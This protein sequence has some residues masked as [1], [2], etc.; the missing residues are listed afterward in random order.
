MDRLRRSARRLFARLAARLPAVHADLA[1]VYA[2]APTLAP[3]RPDAPRPRI[4]MARERVEVEL[5]HNVAVVFAVFEMRNLDDA[6]ELDVAFPSVGGNTSFPAFHGGALHR[7]TA[8][9]GPAALW[10]APIE[11]FG[12]PADHIH[13]VERTGDGGDYPAWQVWRQRFAR[14]ITVVK[15]R[16]VC[17]FNAFK[18]GGRAPFTY[19]LRTGGFWHGPIGEAVVRV[20]A[21][22]VPL[23][24]I[25]EAHPAGY[26]LDAAAGSL[27]WRFVDLDPQDDISLLISQRVVTTHYRGVVPESVVGFNTRRAE[28]GERVL[29]GGRLDPGAPGSDRDAPFIGGPRLVSERWW[30]LNVLVPQG[31]VPLNRHVPEEAALLIAPIRID[32][33]TR[34]EV[35]RARPHIRHGWVIGTVIEIDGRRGIAAEALLD[36]VEAHRFSSLFSAQ[37]PTDGPPLRRVLTPETPTGPVRARG[38]LLPAAGVGPDRLLQNEGP[39]AALTL[40]PRDATHADGRPAW[41]VRLMAVRDPPDPRPDASPVVVV[42]TLRRDA[43]GLSIAVE[44]VYELH[45]VQGLPGSGR[46]FDL[47]ARHPWVGPVQWDDGDVSRPVDRWP[48]D[49][50]DAGRSPRY[51]PRPPRVGPET[52][53]QALS[54]VPHRLTALGPLV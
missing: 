11:D 47:E 51:D 50:A 24:A 1:P 54:M 15:V 7:F 31:I 16:Y 17:T 44:R 21:L 28:L 32:A 6:A 25:R 39:G 46:R 4:A 41:C 5:W 12:D 2:A 53:S 30:D 42:G 10:S 18:F 27:T 38:W 45:L 3:A 29:V 35:D 40:P 26:T 8:V 33:S 22:G 34:C 43:A 23:Q 36:V 13:P 9:A 49:A 14:G 19:V 37:Q 48:A 20:R 52:T